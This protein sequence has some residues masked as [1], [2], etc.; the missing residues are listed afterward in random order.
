MAASAPHGAL[1]VGATGPTLLAEPG[2]N[3]IALDLLAPSNPVILATWTQHS[4]ILNSAALKLLEVK[5]DEP[6]PQGGTWERG[7]DGKLTGRAFDFARFRLHR[8]LA[9]ATPE[10]LALQETREF[11]DE[12][13]RHGITTEQEMSEPASPGMLL[14][15]FTKAPTPIRIRIMR[16]LLT[17]KVGAMDEGRELP[18]NPTPL[19]T[20]SGTK[21]ILDGTPIEHSAA[22]RQPYADAPGTSGALN[23][24]AKE[25]E[26]MLRKALR[27]GDQPIFHCVGDRAAETLFDAMDATGGA[28]VWSTRRV[29]V[30]HG[31]GVVPAL[32]LR[33]KALGVIVTENPTHFG[34]ELHDLILRR[35]GAERASQFFAF[36]SLLDGGI[37]LGIASD[38]GA[39]PFVDLMFATTDPSRP[40]EAVTREQAVIAYTLTAAYAEFAEKNK[41][42]LEAGKLA[43]LAV[44]SQDIFQVPAEKLPQ[45]ESVLTMVG[46]KIVYRAKA[47]FPLLLAGA[48]AR[49][50]SNVHPPRL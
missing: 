13:I 32:A 19:I 27:D 11:L 43:D 1:I 29:R 12:A 35:L 41:G 23:F 37:R 48:G 31:D 50:V 10:A 46:G 22:L 6:N 16:Y 9:E 17:D 18:R 5:E 2:A 7:A 33:A 21:W 25:V 3:R 20:V 44:L 34:L 47:V 40:S 45:T 26:V 36:R 39:N 15:L 30:E 4:V 8:R 28:K 38:G 42:S 24:P 14:Q 49:S